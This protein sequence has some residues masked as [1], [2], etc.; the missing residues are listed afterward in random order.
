MVGVLL[1]V[2]R[3]YPNDQYLTISFGVVETD[4]KDSWSHF[5]KLLFEDIGES[6]WCFIYDTL[7]VCHIYITFDNLRLSYFLF[8]AGFGTSI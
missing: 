1:I 5:I 2:V 4:T 3:R 8:V 7:K 6:S